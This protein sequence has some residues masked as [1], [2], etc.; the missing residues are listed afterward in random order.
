MTGAGPES[1]RPY[2]GNLIY[3]PIYALSA[4]LTLQ[5]ARRHTGPERRAWGW[6]ALGIFSWG[7]GQMVYTCLYIATKTNPFP[8][9]ADVGY[10]ALIPCFVLGIAHFPRL[11]HGRLQNASFLLDIM[12]VVL[13]CGDLLWV[14]DVRATA[15]AYQGQAF[16]LSIALAYP[17]T[18]LA[19]CALLL[20]LMLWRPRHLTVRQLG[21]LALGLGLFLLADLLYAYRTSKNLYELGQLLDTLWSWGAV[22]FGIAAFMGRVGAGTTHEASRTRTG[23]VRTGTEHLLLPNAAIVVVYAV[24]FMLHDPS[25]KNGVEINP[26][27]AIVTLLVLLRQVLGLVDNTRLHRCLA[28]Q[29]EHDHLTG[30]FNRVNLQRYLAESISTASHRE[31]LVAVLFLDLDRMKLVND[32]LGHPAGDHVLKEMAHRLVG[33]VGVGDI[34]ARV[35]GDEFV[36]VLTGLRHADEATRVAERILKAVSLP[37]TIEGQEVFLTASIGLTV[38]PTETHD[39]DIALKQADIAMYQAKRHGKATWCWYDEQDT[40]TAVEQVRLDTHLRLA[41]TR[42]EFEVHYQPIVRLVD[43]VVVGYEALLRWTSPVLGAVPPAKF[44]PVAEAHGL[45]DPLG[46]WV[47]HTALAQIRT[48]RN[49]DWPTIYVTVNVSAMQF[50]R[51]G[52]VASLVAILT[53]RDLPGD[54]LVLELTESALITD[55][56]RSVATLRELSAFGIRV[57]LDDFGTGYSSLSYLQQLPVQVLKVDRSFVKAMDTLNVTLVQAMVTMAHGLGLTV[58]AEGI[59]ETGQSEILRTLGCDMGQG[60]LFGRPQPAMLLDR[61]RSESGRP[62]TSALTLM[63][64]VHRDDW[65]GDGR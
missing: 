9:L 44:I 28:Y 49:A 34:L 57:A 51:E 18:D 21:M 47:L 33:T 41:L 10:L 54:A 40:L 2:L 22:C 31:Q 26:T 62:E 50:L 65:A 4:A 6:L 53:E 61:Q 59:E 8:S 29:A 52:F 39:A 20:S 43:G 13:A 56:T 25:L 5:T 64:P 55:M 11:I 48:W 42:G 46:D 12:I 37:V 38:C 14:L 19:L 15:E 32:S 35:G 45:I 36:V 17:I 63:V 1:L 30:L 3:F 16:A 27:L 23:P 24:F 7:L 58:V 60:Y